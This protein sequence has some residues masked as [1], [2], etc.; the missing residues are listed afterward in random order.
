MKILKKIF[1]VIF[2]NFLLIALLLFICDIFI[3]KELKKI[4][5]E[6]IPDWRFGQLIINFQ[7]WMSIAKNID[8]I[9]FLEEDDFIKHFKDFIRI[10][11]L[12]N[13]ED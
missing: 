12:S 13:K 8:D 5:Q 11:K 3:Y 10:Y 4:H 7:R 1:L 9:F 6:T 2:F